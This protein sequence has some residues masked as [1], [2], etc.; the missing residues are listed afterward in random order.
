MPNSTRFEFF[1]SSL[2]ISENCS[3]GIKWPK[4]ISNVSIQERY[5]FNSDLPTYPLVFSIKNKARF[6]EYIFIV[7][8]SFIP[9]KLYCEL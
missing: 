1:N 5:T 7:K 4:L 6:R 9:R 8:K 3:Y 2:A